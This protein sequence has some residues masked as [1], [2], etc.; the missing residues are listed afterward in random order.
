[1]K[2]LFLSRWYPFPP[3]NGSKLRIY[4]LLQGLAQVHDVTLLT[5]FEQEEQNLIEISPPPQIRAIQAVPRQ[6]FN[7]GGLRA[8]LGYFSPMPRSVLDTYS[9]EMAHNLQQ[10]LAGE[11]FD[12]VI[13]SQFD[14][15]VYSAHFRHIPA[16]LEEIELGALYERY[17]Q[18]K[19]IGQ[20]IRN[21]LTWIKHRRYLSSLLA[22]F[23]MCTV[24]SQRE[25]EILTSV[26]KPR[27][28]V[29]VV[30]NSVSLRDYRS[31]K[32][33]TCT[34]TLIFTGSF[35][36]APNHAAMEWFVQHVWPQVLV[37]VP[38]AQLLITGDTGGK[39]L[40]SLQGVTLTGYVDELQPLVAGAAVSIAP[41]HTGGGSRLK[42]LEAMALRTPVVATP[43]GAEGLDAEAGKHLLIAESPQD[44]ASATISLLQSA[45]LRRQVAEAGYRLVCEQYD[46]A[47]VLPRFLAM[48]EQIAGQPKIEPSR[49]AAGESALRNA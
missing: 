13:A 21:G 25:K 6:A 26:I 38:D 43:K 34:N 4:N 29:E 16:L 1:M 47:V 11:H 31:A 28:A 17:T 9:A 10:L 32:P 41:I 2:I 40:P 49:V 19:S 46:S 23:R 5:F 27:V 35:R 15:A 20:R 42:I 33:H 12:L 14:M 22:N 45:T 3:N 18:A 8:R 30:P 36:F 24:A 39:S 7:P 48:I 44:F 37:Q